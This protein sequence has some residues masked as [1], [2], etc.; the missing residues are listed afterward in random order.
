MSRSF[1]AIVIGGGMVGAATAFGLQRLGMKTVML[2]EGDTAFRAA[3]GN[4]GLVWVQS[5]G[6]DFPSYA[7]WTET[8]ASH[9]QS[10]SDEIKEITGIET[11]YDRPGGF[12]ICLSEEELTAREDKYRRLSQHSNSFRYEMLGPEELRER[13]PGLGPDVVGGGFSPND[14]HAN[15]L[16]LLRGLHTAFAA[17]SGTIEMEA[18]VTAIGNKSGVFAV[19]TPK[20]VFKAPKLVLAA[21]LGNRPLAPMVGLDVPVEP[22]RGQIMVTERLQPFLN[23]PISTVRQT[24]EGSVMLGD[25]HEDVGFD[26]NTSAAIMQEIADRAVRKF[27][28]LKRA[29]IVRTWGA[30]R[31][32][33]PDGHPIYAQSSSQPGAFTAVCHSGVTLAA[34]HAYAW[35]EAVRDGAIPPE[36]MAMNPERFSTERVPDATH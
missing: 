30:L 31:V 25:S 34:G 10:L 4:F 3:R 12:D 20:G 21:G 1:D 13:L 16:Y 9:W 27:P 29:Q 32:M 35:A 22:L 15:P 36:L 14:G 17:K 23:H 19:T 24:V 7:R 18:G 5:K 11:G 8:S 33:T 28:V 26:N 2:D 6:I